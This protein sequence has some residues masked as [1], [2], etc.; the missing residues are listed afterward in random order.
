ML[1]PPNMQTI[2]MTYMQALFLL[3]HTKHRAR[4]NR[5]IVHKKNPAILKMNRGGNKYDYPLYPGGEVLK[6]SQLIF[7]GSGT[8]NENLPAQLC[9]LKRPYSEEA[10]IFL[11]SN[12]LESYLLFREEP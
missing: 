2:T 3:S 7:S 1:S 8:I 5:A 12:Q 9:W 11:V 6:R 4:G 10:M